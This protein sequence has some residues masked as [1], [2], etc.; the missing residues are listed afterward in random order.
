[1]KESRFAS[2]VI[3][4]SNV[5]ILKHLFHGKCA[6]QFRGVEKYT[7]KI[8]FFSLSDIRQNLVLLLMLSL[9]LQLVI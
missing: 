8:S 1:M 2:A 4:S 3:M 5:V 7:Q 9:L 6:D